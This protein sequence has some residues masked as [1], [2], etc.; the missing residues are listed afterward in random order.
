HFDWTA[1]SSQIVFDFSCV[2]NAMNRDGT[3]VHSVVAGTNCFDDAP[4]L[5]PTDGT[6]AFHNSLAGNGI[7]IANADGSGRR[8]IPNTISGDGWPAW[9]P[10]GQWISFGR[11]ITG[12]QLNYFKVHPDG[13]GLTQLTFVAAGGSDGFGPGR[14]WSIDGLQLYAPG[15]VG[16]APGL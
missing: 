12:Q 4:A 5:S 11:V 3:N 15:T 16:G 6:I 8:K 7:F 14:G 10:D 9:S 13:T 1:D 2:I